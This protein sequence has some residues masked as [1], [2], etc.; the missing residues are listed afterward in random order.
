MI[1][2]EFGKTYV[3]EVSHKAN[4]PIHRTLAF[5]ARGNDITLYSAGYESLVSVNWKTL[6]WFRV[7][8]EV[9][10]MDCEYP[11]RFR[12]PREVRSQSGEPT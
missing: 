4:N 12:L 1:T 2:M 8:E 10:S 9:A 5:S 6:P 7:I 3:V 11:N